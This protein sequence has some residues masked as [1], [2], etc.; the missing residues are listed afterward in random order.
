MLERIPMLDPMKPAYNVNKSCAGGYSLVSNFN[1]D[2]ICHPAAMTFCS[3][4]LSLNCGKVIREG[5]GMIPVEQSN[6]DDLTSL[7]VWW[8][9]CLDSRMRVCRT[10]EKS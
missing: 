9:G 7:L 3:C 10:T 4:T 6:L 1:M 8:V 2:M 5:H